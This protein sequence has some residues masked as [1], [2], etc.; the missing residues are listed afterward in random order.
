MAGKGTFVVEAWAPWKIWGG[1]LPTPET[2]PPPNGAS[3]LTP[4]LLE[5]Y[6]VIIS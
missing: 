4:S 2:P 1:H 5:K 3:A 6:K